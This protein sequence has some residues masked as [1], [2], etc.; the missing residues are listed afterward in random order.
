MLLKEIVEIYNLLDSFEVTGYEIKSYLSNIRNKD[1]DINVHTLKVEKGSTDFVRITIPGTNGKINGGNAPTLGVLGRLGGIGAR[2]EVTGFVS[3]GDGALAVLAVA[4]KIL[5]M[6]NKGDL[7]K[8]DVVI[9][10]HI[11]PDAPTIPHDPVPF[12]DSP[13]DMVT[14]NSEEVKGNLDAIISVDTTKGNRIINHNGFAISPTVK[15]G[16]ILKVSEDLLDIMERTTGKSP[17]VLPIT[18]Q[19]I[20]PYGN[21]IHHI[22]SIMQPS[23]ATSSPVVG[24]A[25][26]T[27][28]IVAG[29]ATGATSPYDVEQ[30]ARYV[31][32]VCKDFGEGKV[33][34]YDENEWDI[35]KKRYGDLKILQTLGNNI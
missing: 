35:I 22:N 28:S 33:S 25:I 16:F 1:V 23:T 9:S 2:P 13:V 31:L 20:T 7:L 34:F 5:D 19:D 27:E 12:M 21:N 6:N 24:I 18:N 32:E 11:C 30:T 17:K 4:A 8:G 10:T 26:T 14:M 29:C 15:D 3:D